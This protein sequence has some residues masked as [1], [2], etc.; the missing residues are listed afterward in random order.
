MGYFRTFWRFWSAARSG[1]DSDAGHGDTRHTTAQ[2]LPTTVRKLFEVMSIT[3]LVCSFRR[4]GCPALL[5][6][7]SEHEKVCPYAS[8][9]RCMVSK[10]CLTGPYDDAFRDVSAEHQ[11]STYDVLVTRSTC[12]F[13]FIFLQ[14]LNLLIPFDCL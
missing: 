11:F 14:Q 2:L 9:M 5:S 1:G 12:Y 6:M 3:R 7:I 10:C 13:S 4:N 8:Q